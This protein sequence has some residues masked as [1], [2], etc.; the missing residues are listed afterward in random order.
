[1]VRL[2]NASLRRH[3]TPRTQVKSTLQELGDCSQAKR[4]IDSDVVQGPSV[5]PASLGSLTTHCSSDVSVR[6]QGARIRCGDK[7]P[8]KG[9]VFV[10]PGSRRQDTGAGG[11]GQVIN[12][13]HLE[14]LSGL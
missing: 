2:K 12:K 8:E 5:A 13:R 14:F 7:I 4:E 1:M 9:I 10:E 3:L 6:A 11:E